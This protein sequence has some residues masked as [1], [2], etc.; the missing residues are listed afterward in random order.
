M[1]LSFASYALAM[2][3]RGTIGEGR[4][5][6]KEGHNFIQLETILHDQREIKHGKEAIR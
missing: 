2:S 1:V 5:D 4:T 3:P 6:I